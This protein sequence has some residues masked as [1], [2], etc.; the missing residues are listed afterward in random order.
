VKLVIDKRI[1]AQFD[2]AKVGVVVC[3]GIN[4]SGQRDELRQAL[5]E[6]CWAARQRLDGRVLSEIPEVAVWREAYRQFGSKPSDYHSSIESLLR[7]VLKGENL[8]SINPLV[9]VYNVISLK[10]ML[11]AGGEDLDKIQGDLHLTYAGD[12]EEAVQVLG[13]PEPQVPYAGEVIYRDDVG[14]ICR[15][16]N[17]REAERTM[18]TDKTE[19]A[20]LVVEALEVTAM[21]RL[22]E[23]VQE[24]TKL[25]GR[26]C[27]GECRY[28]MLNKNSP[29][30]ELSVS[31]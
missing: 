9:D 10:Y 20:I 17:W 25:V 4:N 7:R 19:R 2:Q 5:I 6:Q 15:R 31:A 1:F 30:V 21:E 18:L 8:N 23:A 29:E 11:P 26:F 24:L 3:D 22:E 28:A 12:D 27:G 13:K 16:W 14:T